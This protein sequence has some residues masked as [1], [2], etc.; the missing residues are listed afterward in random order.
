MLGIYIKHSGQIWFV[1]GSDV[2]DSEGKMGPT[3]R[4]EKQFPP[5]IL[6]NDFKGHLNIFLPP[7]YCMK[8]STSSPAY[9][10]PLKGQGNEAGF[11]RDFCINRFGISPPNT[12]IRAVPIFEYENLREYEAKFGTA[13]M[14][15]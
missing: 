4:F 12:T 3:D 13:R 1:S 14:A 2:T 5:S 10:V 8:H 15:V 7:C 9:R 11:F 6:Y